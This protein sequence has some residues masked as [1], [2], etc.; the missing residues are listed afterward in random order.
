[1]ARLCWLYTCLCPVLI[2]SGCLPGDFVAEGT[3]EDGDGWYSSEAGGWDC[4]DDELTAYPG[5]LEICTDGHDNDCDGLPDGD[6]LPYVDYFAE[7]LG[8]DWQIQQGSASH[9]A[10]STNGLQLLQTPVALAR[11][12]GAECWSSYRFST[13]FAFEQDAAFELDLFLLA[14]EQWDTGDRWPQDG[15]VLRWD[16]KGPDEAEF[17]LWRLDDGEPTWLNYSNWQPDHD[18]Y[19]LAP[20]LYVEVRV[21]DEKTELT[22]KCG[23]LGHNTVMRL[24]DSSPKRRLTGG[25]GLAVDGPVAEGQLTGVYLDP[26]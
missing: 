8:V 18:S 16:R 24:G 19:M 1:M 14:G 2:A 4:E 5:H 17:W 7:G 22:V 11:H 13:G 3:D 15:Y 10:N 20:Y 23:A 6:A 26:L 21:E 25:I 12:L 9:L